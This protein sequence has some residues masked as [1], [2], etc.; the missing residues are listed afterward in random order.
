[1]AEKPLLLAIDTATRF[2]GL[3]LYDGAVIRSEAFKTRVAGLGGYST[4]KTGQVW[5]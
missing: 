4:E 2:A 5:L 1:M 3:A